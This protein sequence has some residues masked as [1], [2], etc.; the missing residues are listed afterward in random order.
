MRLKSQIFASAMV[1]QA[2]AAGGF[3]AILKSGSEEAG[4]I[5]IVHLKAPDK[6]DFYG[7]APQA[8]IDDGNAGERFFECLGTDLQPFA[9]REAIDRQVRF[10]PDCWIVEVETPEI[11]SGIKIAGSADM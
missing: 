6:A 1:R 2:N 3:A 5:F 9:L 7:P 8:L 4:A 10:D 11:L